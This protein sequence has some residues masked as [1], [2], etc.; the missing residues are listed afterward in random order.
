MQWKT[1][2]VLDAI[3]HAIEN[4]ENVLDPQGKCSCKNLQ[5]TLD[6]PG[7]AMAK[8]RNMLDAPENAMED[9]ENVLDEPG[10]VMENFENVLYWERQW[11]TLR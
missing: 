5:N 2:N 10:N 8:L 3:E 6:A 9:L 7:N 4:L 1:L 11:P